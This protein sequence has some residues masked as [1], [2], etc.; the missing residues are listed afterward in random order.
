MTRLAASLAALTAVVLGT[1]PLGAQEPATAPGI[2]APETATDSAAPFGPVDGTLLRAGASSYRITLLRDAGPG[3]LGTRTVEVNEASLG[4]T[5]TWL[6]VERRSGSAVP[7]ADSLWLSRL[8]LAPLRWVASVGRTQLAASFARDSVFGAVHNYAGR[9]SFA[10]GVL[11]GV[12]VTAGMTEKIVELLSLRVG[13]RAAASLLLVDTGTPRALP[14][15]LVVERE[16]RARTPG[17]E[18]DCWVVHLRAGAME[19]WLWVEKSRRTVVRAEQ[20]S[21]V[22]RIVSERI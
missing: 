5:P 13:Y 11:P 2:V 16:E 3:D 4:G 20:T 19:E 17:G 9:S 8:D 15:E 21:A 7:T 10:A 14:A 6:I 22:G 18:V 12:L 1:V